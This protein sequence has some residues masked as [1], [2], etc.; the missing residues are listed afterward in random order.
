MEFTFK[1]KLIH[2][3]F[4]QVFQNLEIWVCDVMVVVSTILQKPFCNDVEEFEWTNTF[5]SWWRLSGKLIFQQ[6]FS[7]QKTD[8]VMMVFQPEKLIFVKFFRFPRFLELK[9]LRWSI[10]DEK[11][12]LSNFCFQKNSFPRT[13]TVKMVHSRRGKYTF[14]LF[15]KNLVS[16]NCHR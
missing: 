16:S 5:S 4:T 3:I 8:S 13:E 11:S 1:R 15:S 10:L 12:T 2:W 6:F 9:P 14:Q 7:F